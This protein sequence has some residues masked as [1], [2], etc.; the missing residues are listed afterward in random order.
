[1]PLCEVKCH[2]KVIVLLLSSHVFDFVWVFVFGSSGF[3]LKFCPLVSCF[4][5]NFL[6]L[7][8]SQPSLLLTCILLVSTTWVFVCLCSVLFVMHLLFLFLS[9]SLCQSCST[10]SHPFIGLYFIGPLFFDSFCILNVGFLIVLVW[11]LDFESAH[12]YS[13]HFCFY[14]PTFLCLAFGSFFWWS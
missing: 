4:D 12:Y 2:S 7:S 3:I 5:F 14:W 9:V 13:L 10:C 6:P 8:L 11:I 1:M